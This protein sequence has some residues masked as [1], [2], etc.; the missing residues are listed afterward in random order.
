M[1]TLD[2]FS[3]LHHA[4][5]LLG[6]SGV[7]K[8]MLSKELRKTA[9]WFHYSADY[10]I[11]TR[12]LAEDIVDNIKFKIMQMEDPFVANLLRSDSIYIHH[13]ITVENLDPVSTFLGMYGDSNQGGLDKKTFLQRQSLYRDAE[14]GSMQEVDRFINKSWEIYRCERFINDASGSLC[15]ICDPEDAED[16]V[17]TALSDHTLILYIQS[18]PRSEED[19]KRRAKTDPK[20]LFYHPTF[21]APVLDGKPDNGLGIDPLDFARPLFPELLAF[22]KPRYA[23]M[24]E[25]LG[26][27]IGVSDLFFTGASDTTIPDSDQFMENI[28]QVIIA[29]AAKSEAA[30]ERLERYIEICKRRADLRQDAPVTAQEIV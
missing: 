21:I 13:N 23:T 14:I 10:R 30:G 12:Y 27:T 9:N 2:E 24:A 29:E 1:I 8:T 25:R 11:G 18:D 7:G 16:P 3:R 5:T 17:L 19:L 6:M 22:R 15:E 26:F 4:I 28:Y 20:P